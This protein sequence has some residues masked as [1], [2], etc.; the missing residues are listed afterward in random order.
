MRSWALAIAAA[1]V[2]PG[3]L[4]ADERYDLGRKVFLEQAQPSCSLCH[5]LADAG[6]TGAIGPDLDELAPTEEQVLRAV[7]SGVGVMPAFA[8]SLSD[9]QIAAVAHY[10]A[11]ASSR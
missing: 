1:V 10:V 7:S 4:W 9:E 3:Q 2:T 8:A 6:A 11:T 5:T